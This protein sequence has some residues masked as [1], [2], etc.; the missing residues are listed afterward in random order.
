MEEKTAKNKQKKKNSTSLIMLDTN[1]IC[2][3]LYCQLSRPKLQLRLFARKWPFG[4]KLAKK[5]Q[6][7]PERKKNNTLYKNSVCMVTILR[8]YYFTG[9]SLKKKTLLQSSSRPSDLLIRDNVNVLL[10]EN[11][12]KEISHALLGIPAVNWLKRKK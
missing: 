1:T 4:L 8:H 7:G 12:A 3:R 6:P 2:A 11:E 10:Y 9:K 5:V